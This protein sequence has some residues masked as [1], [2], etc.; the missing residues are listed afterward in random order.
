MKDSIDNFL[1]DISDEE[2]NANVPDCIRSQVRNFGSRCLRYYKTA[3][4][5]EIPD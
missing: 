5:L 1:I 3:N 4:K 2:L